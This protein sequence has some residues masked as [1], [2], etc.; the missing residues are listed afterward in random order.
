[1]ERQQPQQQQ[2]QDQEEEEEEEAESEMDSEAGPASFQIQV[3]VQDF[4]RGLQRFEARGEAAA[5]AA[6]DFHKVALVD[7]YFPSDR[8]EPVG[9]LL[10]HDVVR[11]RRRRRQQFARFVSLLDRD[12][13][14]RQVWGV[15][16]PLD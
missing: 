7:S 12:H 10:R 8:P 3:D 16:V 2:P 6:A 1:M 5:A 15:H 11:R 13:C 9:L 14:R 4:E